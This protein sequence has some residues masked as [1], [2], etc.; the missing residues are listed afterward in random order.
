M[1]RRTGRP[2]RSSTTVIPH[3][4]IDHIQNRSSGRSNSVSRATLKTPS[5]ATTIDQGWSAARSAVP[6]TCG[7]SWLPGCRRRRAR[8]DCRERRPDPR[9]D[10]GS[11]S[12]PGRPVL[13]RR[14]A[15]AGQLRGVAL[16]D[17]VRWR[18]CQSPWPISRK[19]ASGLRT[20]ACRRRQRGLDRDSRLGRAAQ[21]RV[22][23]LQRRPDRDGQR[24]RGVW[25]GQPVGDRAACP[26]PTAVS[27]DSACPWKRPSAMN[28]DSPCRTRT[29]VAS[30]PSGTSEPRLGAAQRVP[31]SRIV[32]RSR[33]AS[34]P[35]SPRRPP[36]GR[37]R[38]GPGSSARPR[39]A[40]SGR[41]ASR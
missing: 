18:P 3:R 31:P 7:R 33:T 41:G 10:I 30:R 29:R 21:R 6:A 9:R 39:A 40:G 4:S 5:C 12:P 17:L 14:P 8:Q 25:R 11:D 22:D 19:P 26:R 20:G 28:V 15:P 38:R 16:G 27:G 32:H 13:Q 2:A 34:W 35:G 1:R 36:P 23:E 37:R 24:R